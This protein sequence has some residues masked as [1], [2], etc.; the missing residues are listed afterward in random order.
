MKRLS[1]CCLALLALA[2]APGV[3]AESLRCNGRIMEVGEP[4][5]N[6][7]RLCGEPV[8]ADSYCRPVEVMPPRG[9]RWPWYAQ[10][11][12]CRPV[13]EWLYDRGPGNL[14]A[15]VRFEAGRIHSI[16]YTQR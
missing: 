3:R 12:P 1:L 6:V 5:V 13:D 8:A 2:A 10:D 4:R 14:M 15:L 7:V 16:E 11:L 9:Q